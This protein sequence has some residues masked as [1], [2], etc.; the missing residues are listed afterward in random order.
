MT[1]LTAGSIF[2]KLGFF[3]LAMMVLIVV[4]SEPSLADDETVIEITDIDGDVIE[5]EDI[6]DLAI[7]V[8][9]DTN[10][11]ASTSI[12][13]PNIPDA[14]LPQAFKINADT[15]S[16]SENAT[17]SE[18][19]ASSENVK[20]NIIEVN[21]RYYLL[22]Y[23]AA[24]DSF[25]RSITQEA[26]PGDLIEIEITATNKS[27][28]VVKEVEMVNSIPTGPVEFIKDSI[29]FDED[30]GF[31]SISKT[32]QTFFAPETEIDAVDINFIKW[33]VFSLGINDTLRLSYRIKIA[34]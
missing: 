13:I 16:A 22:E 33:Q 23:D 28:E 3:S 26:N 31:Y 14:A 18:D 7:P 5:L 21:E 6:E 12:P 27:D 9:T 20:I 29:T 2:H 24:S 32:G 17:L 4:S 30:R 1:R 25:L 34:Q 19:A 11:D 15:V 10:L 8:E